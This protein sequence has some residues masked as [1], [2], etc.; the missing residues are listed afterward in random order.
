MLLASQNVTFLWQ[1][2]EIKDAAQTPGHVSVSF[3]SPCLSQWYWVNADN[4]VSEQQQTVENSMRNVHLRLRK[5][6]EVG[7]NPTNDEQ[8]PQTWNAEQQEVENKRYKWAAMLILF[9]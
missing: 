6:P 7:S 9:E 4:T 3:L 5:K 1:K 2:P 8:E